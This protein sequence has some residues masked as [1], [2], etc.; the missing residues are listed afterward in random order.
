MIL[1]WRAVCGRCQACTRGRPWYCFNTHNATQ[2]MTLEGGTALSPVTLGLRD[3]R[4]PAG[5]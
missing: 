4:A 5:A 1:N 2:Q 3:C